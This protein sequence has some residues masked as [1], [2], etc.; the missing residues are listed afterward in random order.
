MKETQNKRTITIIENQN[1]MVCEMCNEAMTSEEYE[2][3]DMCPDCRDLH[4]M[5]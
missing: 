4:T 5:F 2:F 3:C 1:D